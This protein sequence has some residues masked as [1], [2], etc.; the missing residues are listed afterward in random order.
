MKTLQ[1]LSEKFTED[2]AAI[3]R[4]YRGRS[5]K[6]RLM[7]A[8]LTYALGMVDGGLGAASVREKWEK[9]VDRLWCARQAEDR[10]AR[11]HLLATLAKAEDYYFS[12]RP[13]GGWKK[14]RNSRNA[15]FCTDA[16]GVDHYLT[17]E[18]PHAEEAAEKA[19][20]FLGCFDPELAVKASVTDIE[21]LLLIW[22][23]RHRNAG[24]AGKE[25]LLDEELCDLF[26]KVGCPA[27]SAE[28][29]RRQRL[30][31]EKTWPFVKIPDEW[32]REGELVHW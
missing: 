29:V 19:L 30:K 24:R 7:I 5:R 27:A 8:D 12:P 31:W 21:R 16:N 18:Q 14:P 22:I 9:H 20:G 13:R 15:F 23:D 1:E 26:R 2:R 32:R 10:A 6:I 17:Q 4:A 28:A 3:N 25:Q 11:E